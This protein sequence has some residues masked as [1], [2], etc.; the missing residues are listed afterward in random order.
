MTG[1]GERL[2]YRFGFG[3]RTGDAEHRGITQRLMGLPEAFDQVA[4][5]F[6]TARRPT[7]RTSDRPRSPAPH[8]GPSER[9]DG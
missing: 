4:G 7:C 5:S 2:S 1:E 3:A 6:S 9:S 8:V